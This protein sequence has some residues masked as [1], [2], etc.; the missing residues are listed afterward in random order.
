MFRNVFGIVVALFLLALPAFAQRITF[1]SS[2]LDSEGHH[3]AIAV[4]YLDG[5][6]GTKGFYVHDF[7]N[8]DTPDLVIMEYDSFVLFVFRGDQARAFYAKC[9]C[10]VNRN[11]KPVAKSTTG[12]A[13]RNKT[14]K[15]TLL[16]LKDERIDVIFT[17]ATAFLR[18]QLKLTKEGTERSD[19]MDNILR[20]KVFGGVFLAT[21]PRK[22]FQ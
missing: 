20:N 9:N 13:L 15:Y 18:E 12:F 19:E 4:P 17:E 2:L 1:V 14:G 10:L 22:W 7:N 3:L 21:Y 8:D 6:Q 16:S 11:M 5:R